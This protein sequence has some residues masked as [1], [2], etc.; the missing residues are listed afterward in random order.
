MTHTSHEVNVNSF[1][2]TLVQTKTK[3]ERRTMM[4]K[5]M[6]LAL[7]LA[8]AGLANAGLVLTGA[9]VVANFA[10]DN[11]DPYV[12][13]LVAEQGVNVL[14]FGLTPAGLKDLSFVTD[15]GMVT[16]ADIGAALGNIRVIQ[17]SAASSTAGALEAGLHFTAT[18]DKELLTQGAGPR[19]F[20]MSEDFSQVLGTLYTIPE[21]MTMVLLGLGGLFLRKK[22]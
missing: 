22:K 19:V 2:P 12:A 18:T 13:N 20:L 6:V 17:F 14:A 1:V 8:V 11:G 5:L 21:P 15:Y 7:V 10:S 4:K 9:G 16:G 3:F